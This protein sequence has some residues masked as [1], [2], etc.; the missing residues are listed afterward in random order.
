VEV[1]NEG[2]DSANL[3]EPMRRQVEQRSGGK[4]A[5]HLLDGGYLKTQ[6]L[7]QANELGVQLFVPPHTAIN[8]S[9]HGKELQIRP[10]DSPAVADWKQR[11]ASEEGKQIYKERASTSETVNADLRSFRG[12]VQLTVRGLKKARCVALWSALANNMMHFGTALLT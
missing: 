7:E 11:M 2:S 5:Q 12:L 10:G 6:D 1:S 8:A 3:S 4:V 9:N